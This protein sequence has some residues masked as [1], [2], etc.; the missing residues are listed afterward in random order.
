MLSDFTFLFWPFFL[1][2]FNLKMAIDFQFSSFFL[3]CRRF[4]IVKM[5]WV[6][7]RRKV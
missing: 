1:F 7:M 5:F 4:M 2:F 6:H 3:D